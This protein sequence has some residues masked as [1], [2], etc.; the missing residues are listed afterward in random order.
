MFK[1]IVAAAIVWARTFGAVSDQEPARIDFRRDVQPLFIA[2]YIDCHGPKQQKNGVRLDRRRD[3]MKGG[4]F[5]MIG[6]GNSAASRFSLKH[7]SNRYGPQMPL[8][9]L[10][11]RNKSTSS[12]RGS[13]RG[14]C[15]RTMFPGCVLRSP[16]T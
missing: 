3:A 16:R 1:Q 8:D 6:P 15:G 10:C 9:G 5:T 11:N 7:L 2:Y 12:R 14:P 13:T 4:T